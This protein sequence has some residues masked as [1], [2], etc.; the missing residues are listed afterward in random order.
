M[1]GFSLEFNGFN[2]GTMLQRILKLRDGGAVRRFHTLRTNRVQ[3]VAEHSHGVAMLVLAV[4]PEAEC[5]VLR[6]AL[7]HDL[8]EVMTGDI[9]ATSKWLSPAL[10]REENL[11]AGI[12]RE[13]HGL[14]LALSGFEKDL[15]KWC[16]MMELV[17]WTMEEG[18]LG[19]DYAGEVTQRGL[20]FLVARE[21]P[22]AEARLLLDEVIA[23]WKA[24]Q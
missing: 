1:I 16:D 10:A 19:N 22:T 6:A 8:P 9:P 15:L 5:S 12:F 4:Y 23:E 24:S 11:L 14:E 20:D 3:S 17:L 7:Y 21:P 13:H 2:G 18:T